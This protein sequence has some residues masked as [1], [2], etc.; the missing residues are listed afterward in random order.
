MLM[1]CTMPTMAC[2]APYASLTVEERACCQEMA[3]HC[4]E[5]GMSRSHSCCQHFASPGNDVFAKASAVS[6]H[7]VAAH[8]VLAAQP[9]TPRPLQI[10]NH[11]AF[12]VSSAHAPPGHPFT[13]TALRI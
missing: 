5:M 7:P 1:L 10:D 8:S 4:E 2:L 6:L 12:V 13:I 3:G 9:V 11:P